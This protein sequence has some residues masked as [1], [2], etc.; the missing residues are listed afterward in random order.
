[1]PMQ[2][3]NKREREW[4]IEIGG[5]KFDENPFAYQISKKD[6]TTT[7]ILIEIWAQ[8]EGW[9]CVCCTNFLIL[10]FLAFMVFNRH[11][12]LKENF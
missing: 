9:I 2:K 10:V 5:N 6:E 11:H 8:M 4:G 7:Y 3:K 12:S 1:M